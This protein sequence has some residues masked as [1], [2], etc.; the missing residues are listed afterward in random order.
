MHESNDEQDSNHLGDESI[1][2]DPV[3]KKLHYIDP[4]VLEYKRT[5]F[6]QLLTNETEVMTGIELRD[7]A[8]EHKLTLTVQDTYVIMRIHREKWEDANQTLWD[9]I[10]ELLNE[11]NATTIVREKL[12]LVIKNPDLFD[13]IGFVPIPLKVRHE[14]AHELD[15][16]ENKDDLNNDNDNDITI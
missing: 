3:L 11:W 8:K 2:E 13:A 15:F 10:A 7:I 4:G 14:T 9:A 5:I 12:N 1:D 6:Q 16:N